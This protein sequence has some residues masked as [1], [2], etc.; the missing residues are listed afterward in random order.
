MPVKRNTPSNIVLKSIGTL[1][2]A[3]AFVAMVGRAPFL[4]DK[5]DGNNGASQAGNQLPTGSRIQTAS[6]ERSMTVRISVSDSPTRCPLQP[7]MGLFSAS[8][9][10]ST[11]GGG[12]STAEHRVAGACEGAGARYIDQVCPGCAVSAGKGQGD[13]PAMLV[14][15]DPGSPTGTV[16]AVTADC[17]SVS[18]DGA[19]IVGSLSLGGKELDLANGT[20]TGIP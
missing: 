4:V 1:V 17:V 18:I 14:W 11:E 3:I 7:S 20:S 12:F 2:L 9:S 16:N 6:L 13:L 19:A 8:F 15:T 10:G 5:V